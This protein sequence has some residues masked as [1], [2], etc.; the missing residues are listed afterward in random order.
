MGKFI[1]PAILIVVVIALYFMWIAPTYE[2]VE[3]LQAKQATLLD[4]LDKS[5]Q[6][7]TLIAQLKSNFEAIPSDQV[8]RLRKMVPDDIDNIRLLIEVNNIAQRGGLII[9]GLNIPPK[10]TVAPGE[11]GTG[12]AGGHGTFSFSFSVHGTYEQL[13]AFYTQLASNL[14]LSDITQF[15]FGPDTAVN[16]KRDSYSSTLTLNTYWLH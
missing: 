6:V 1:T 4:A 9:D 8:D 3:K 13:I 10:P 11:V 16:A 15:S 12:G 14:R 2:N 7:Q 5:K